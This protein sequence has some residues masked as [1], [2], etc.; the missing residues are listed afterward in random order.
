M[1]VHYHLFKNAGTSVERLLRQSLGKAWQSWDKAEPGA[2]IS[3][4]ELQ[5]WLQENPHIRAVSSHQLVPPI[6]EGGF[7]LIPI[8][9][10][11]EPLSRVRS[12]WLFEWQKQK[13]LSEPQ[14]SLR[15]Y[16]EEKFKQKNASVIAN[17]QVSRLCNEKYDEVRL[18]LHRYNHNLL[19]AACAFLDRL[20]FV[21][22]VERYSDSLKLMRECTRAHFP[23]LDIREH[24]ENVTDSSDWSIEQRIEKLRNEIGDELFDELCV[25]NRLD[26]QLYSYACGLFKSQMEQS[27]ESPSVGTVSR[28]KLFR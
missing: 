12:A 11:R 19:P 25:R 23:D 24:R 7:H 9:F 27:Q 18:P 22:L 4:R 6:P 15:D 28:L 14:G 20:P 17:F 5:Q 13:G 1:I 8:V 26:L 16:V 21:G 10:L 3:G 2:K